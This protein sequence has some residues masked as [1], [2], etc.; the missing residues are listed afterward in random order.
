VS[1][2]SARRLSVVILALA[3]AAA[4]WLLGRA[5]T[6]PSLPGRVVPLETLPVGPVP[7]AEAGSAPPA[8]A[9]G[10]VR[11]VV[12]ILGDGMGLVQVAAAAI[13]ELGPDGRFGFERFPVSGLFATRPAGG[14][15]T[16]SDAAATALASGVKTT[17]GRLGEDPDG[18][19]LTTLL[20]A[21]RDAGHP[22]G[23]VTTSSIVDATPAAFVA[24][25]DARHDYRRIAEQLATARVDL[26]AGGGLE[27]VAPE[28]VHQGPLAEAAARGVAIVTDAEAWRTTGRLPVWAIFPGSELGEQPPHPDVA[29]LAGPA[30]RLLGDEATRRG[31]GFF[32]MIE[33]EGIDTAGHARD[34]DR[35]ARA[36]ARL[37]RAVDAAV[38]FAAADGATLVVVTGDHSTGGLEIDSTS[39]A[40][41]L[42]VAWASS[43]HGGEP[44]PAF[45]YGPPSAAAAFTGFHDDTEIHDLLARALGL[46]AARSPGAGPDGGTP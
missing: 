26:L 16:K 2:A 18:R 28:G 25:V 33:E 21:A 3:A 15:V 38:R 20:E 37:D 41:R 32:L 46:A 4:G 12:L 39:T 11:N 9:D 6:G 22:T 36:V 31:S 23:L 29:E 34:F 10:P 30:L 14:L 24:H 44:V 43:Q 27:Q 5:G 7:G 19:R 1:A 35:M 40:D 45:V 42:R 13:R 8:L 17:N